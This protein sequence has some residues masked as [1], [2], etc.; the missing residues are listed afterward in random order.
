MSRV[1]V[2]PRRDTADLVRPD[3]CR[4]VG[5]KGYAQYGPKVPARPGGTVLQPG[6]TPCQV[7]RPTGLSAHLTSRY[8][9]LLPRSTVRLIKPPVPSSHLYA[10][11]N[12]LKK[13][14]EPTGGGSIITSSSNCSRVSKPLPKNK[15]TEV[16]VGQNGLK[17][18]VHLIT[19]HLGDLVAVIPPLLFIAVF[20][21]TLTYSSH[22]FLPTAEGM[23]L[24]PPPRRALPPRSRP[25]HKALHLPGQ[26]LPPRPHPAQLRPGLLR[27]PTRSRP[28]SK[29]LVP[30]IS[31]KRKRN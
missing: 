5:P 18:A 31:Q 1:C 25:L 27:P 26:E 12:K 16:M 15:A 17:L 10:R 24:P 9:P 14:A 2:S 3:P 19:A 11:S 8:L 20:S 29:T 21:Q 30:P 28:P 7:G 22:P 13:D 23:Q 6:R 4:T